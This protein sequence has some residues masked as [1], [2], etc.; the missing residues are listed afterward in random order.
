MLDEKRLGPM[1]GAKYTRFK[2]GAKLIN[3]M[4]GDSELAVCRA[5]S[6]YKT[7]G[8]RNYHQQWTKK[9]STH[10]GI[11]NIG[12]VARMGD[13]RL[14]VLSAPMMHKQ[15]TATPFGDISTLAKGRLYATAGG[16]FEF[17]QEDD[18]DRDCGPCSRCNRNIYS[19]DP[20]H[21]LALWTVKRLRHRT[22]HG[23]FNY[24]TEYTISPVDDVTEAI[25]DGRFDYSLPGHVF[26]I[27]QKEAH[28][29]T[30]PETCSED[31]PS[32]LHFTY[33]TTTCN[34]ASRNP[35]DRAVQDP[36]QNTSLQDKYD[37][38]SRRAFQSVVEPLYPPPLP[39]SP[40]SSGVETKPPKQADSVGDVT[41]PVKTTVH[42]FM[43]VGEVLMTTN[44]IEGSTMKT[45][46]KSKTSKK[47]S[48]LTSKTKMP[49]IVTSK[50]PTIGLIP[51]EESE[52]ESVELFPGPEETTKSM[53]VTEK[54][55]TTKK[56]SLLTPKTRPT[57]KKPTIGLIPEEE[58]EEVSKE[59]FPEP[60][61]SGSSTTKNITKPL[62]TS[63]T[64]TTKFI[65]QAE[66]EDGS[67]E[68]LFAEPVET[69]K[70]TASTK[71]LTTQATTK[72]TT[73]RQEMTTTRGTTK[74]K[75]TETLS[76]KLSSTSLGT[77]S[78]MIPA[79]TPS[80]TSIE[81]ST[82]IVASSKATTSTKPTSPNTT[83]KFRKRPGYIS[84]ITKV[85]KPI[86]T[87]STTMRTTAQILTSTRPTKPKSTVHST[88]EAKTLSSTAVLPEPSTEATTAQTLATLKTT[89]AQSIPTLAAGTLRVPTTSYPTQPGPIR[90]SQVPATSEA[91]PE[92]LPTLPMGATTQKVDVTVS[93]QMQ[94]P[95]DV[96]TTSPYQTATETSARTLVI[97]TTTE[98]TIEGS[99][100]PK[101]GTI[102]HSTTELARETTKI[103]T[104]PPMV[105]STTV[106]TTTEKVYTQK[107]SST[108]TL[109]STEAEKT[110]SAMNEI[111]ASVKTTETAAE[112]ATTGILEMLTQVT[113]P[114]TTTKISATTEAVETTT[115]MEKVTVTPIYI[116]MT[117]PSVISTESSTL[118][119]S[120]TVKHTTAVDRQPTKPSK[121][122]TEINEDDIFGVPLLT[123][124]TTARPSVKSAP[125]G[126]DDLFGEPQ[127]AK[128]IFSD[129]YE[130]S[131][132]P[133]PTQS[134]AEMNQP[135]TSQSYETSISFKVNKREH[136][137]FQLSTVN[138]KSDNLQT[139]DQVLQH[140][141]LQLVNHARSIEYLNQDGSDKTFRSPKYKRRRGYVSRAK[142][143]V[144]KR[145]RVSRERSTNSQER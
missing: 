134:T 34:H 100:A 50:R 96:G 55:K 99:E 54:P 27:R 142:K 65:I 83:K 130:A 95:T 89:T 26:V 127:K 31:V 124:T 47:P 145:R 62:T 123:S 11:F 25:R 4:F 43:P 102:F 40:T 105:T 113:T 77:T 44:K 75:A 107:P 13:L 106:P 12:S 117:N 137:Q 82:V 57:S 10:T 118:P 144:S 60:A 143:I 90:S 125:K 84:T 23:G 52:E 64:T 59:L 80:M 132:S 101:T 72:Q 9:F 140:Q 53:I 131:T 74:Q 37:S 5:R 36:P 3:S 51:E 14:R 86:T 76:T 133:T 129:F 87:K 16:G 70:A 46:E 28:G 126:F 38:W 49:T 109:S 15:K 6:V 136:K 39:S 138:P 61:E 2:L 92:M 135:L 73:K 114:A 88:T 116:E 79:T 22:H 98:T 85:Q 71:K 42:Y 94:M 110:T 115:S 33:A 48:L 78:A 119:T 141:T 93:N 91:L 120:S 20:N 81:S 67:E 112:E 69:T 122:P 1:L 21:L 104:T 30:F 63:T 56:P 35:R 7:V 41:Q 29:S 18:N 103:E 97:E 19:E 121:R 24:E 45:T 58:S 139:P 17:V 111:I 108:T 66:S 32:F 128:I 68:E 8:M